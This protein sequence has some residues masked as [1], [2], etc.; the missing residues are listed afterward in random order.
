LKNGVVDENKCFSAI[1]Q[2]KGEL[3]ENEAELI[4]QSGCIWGC[5][6]CQNICP[7]N[8]NIKITPIKEFYETANPVYKGE[9]DYNKNR[10]FSWRKQD[11]I[12]RNLEI[13]GCKFQ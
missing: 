7:M 3:K 12:N 5:D 2:K 10:A 8:K 6:I 11:V 1:T 4:R 13:S 9:S